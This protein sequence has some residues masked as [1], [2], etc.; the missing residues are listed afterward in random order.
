MLVA[1]LAGAQ[2]PQIDVYPH[3]STA[4]AT[5]RVRTTT[6]PDARNR[7]LCVLYA[8]EDVES[9]DCWPLEGDRAAITTVRYYLLDAGDYAFRSVVYRAQST[10]RS[11]I[12]TVHVI[13]H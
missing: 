7:M 3:L 2:M 5:V 13:G 8:S 11:D 9:M 12:E 6:P 4:P 1:L 10:V